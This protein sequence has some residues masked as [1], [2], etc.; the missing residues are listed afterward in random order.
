MSWWWEGRTED[1]QQQEEEEE[2]EE[3]E[4]EEG[5]SIGYPV[6]IRRRCTISPYDIPFDNFHVTAPSAVAPH[7]TRTS[8]GP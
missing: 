4:E 5:Y 6:P 7:S 3:D 8:N 2:E 1:K